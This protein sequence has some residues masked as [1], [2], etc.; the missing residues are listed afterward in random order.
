MS[1]EQYLARYGYPIRYG[2]VPR[3]WDLSYYQT[4]YT[5]ES[6]SAEMPSAGRPFT[7]QL[8]TDLVAQGITFTPLILHTGVASLESTEPPTTSTIES[9]PRR[10]AWS[11]M[12]ARST[13]GLSPLV[14]PSCARS[15]RSPMSRALTRAG[16]GWSSLFVTPARGIRSIDGLLT[17]MHEPRS[18][19]LSMLQALAGREHIEVTYRAAI[20]ERYLWHEFGDVHLLLP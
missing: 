20:K 18:T 19:H 16:E 11:T 7:P 5:T 8:I 3:Q 17:G 12:R 6:G 2:H 14:R 9:R 15:R 10:R 4:V 1:I 13:A